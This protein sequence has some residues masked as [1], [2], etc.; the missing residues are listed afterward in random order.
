L[1]AIYYPIAFNACL[2][3]PASNENV[4]CCWRLLTFAYGQLRREESLLAL[5]LA[6]IIG[7]K[8]L[9]SKLLILNINHLVFLFLSATFSKLYNN[10]NNNVIMVIIEIIQLHG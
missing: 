8:Q 4:H 7:Q 6:V 1:P 10:N 3:S 9:V 5:S 2:I